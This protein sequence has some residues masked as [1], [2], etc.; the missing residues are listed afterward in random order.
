MGDWDLGAIAG[1]FSRTPRLRPLDFRWRA[2]SGATHPRWR[3]AKAFFEEASW[4]H[5]APYEEASWQHAEDS[6]ERSY[7]EASRKRFRHQGEVH[8]PAYPSKN[9]RVCVVGRPA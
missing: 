3:S 9:V 6:W 7:E 1:A 2:P 8:A 4:Q 5:A